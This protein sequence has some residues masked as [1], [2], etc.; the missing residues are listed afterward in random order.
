MIVSGDNSWIVFDDTRRESSVICEGERADQRAFLDDAYEN[1]IDEDEKEQ[2]TKHCSLRHSILNRVPARASRELYCS[3]APARKEGSYPAP[4]ST[5][6]RGVVEIGEEHWMPD[7]IECFLNVEENN[8]TRHLVAPCGSLPV[9]VVQ[10]TLA[11]MANSREQI[12]DGVGGGVPGTEAKLERRE[13]ASTFS[14]VTRRLCTKCSKARMMILVMLIGRYDEAEARE[15]A[16]L[17]RAA[18]AAPL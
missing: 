5:R 7:A 3:D 16:G 13:E 4:C 17:P 18:S 1:R 14:S 6:D 9:R 8:R 11:D 2:R 12:V 15:P 10:V